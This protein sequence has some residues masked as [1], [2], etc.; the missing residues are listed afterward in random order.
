ML[1]CVF[2]F[3][4]INFYDPSPKQIFLQIRGEKKD[5]NYLFVDK[6]HLSLQNRHLQLKDKILN[7]ISILFKEK[8]N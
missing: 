5:E 3:N 6:K 2:S 1:C 8:Q 7:L 4:V